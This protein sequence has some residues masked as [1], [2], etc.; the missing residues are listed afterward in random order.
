MLMYFGMT[1]KVNKQGIITEQ[2]SPPRVLVIKPPRKNLP[3]TM[4]NMMVI[5]DHIK[6][7]TKY[8]KGVFL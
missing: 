6:N 7:T 4:E 3:L 1:N 5:I 2:M 8:L